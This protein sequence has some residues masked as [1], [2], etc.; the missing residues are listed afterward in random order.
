M[1][2]II[3]ILNNKPIISHRSNNL[4]LA[5]REVGRFIRDGWVAWVEIENV[6]LVSE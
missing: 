3:V 6:V 1:Y 4:N 2:K 5:K